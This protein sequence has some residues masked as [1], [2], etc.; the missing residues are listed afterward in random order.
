M[1]MFGSAHCVLGVPGKE[2]RPVGVIPGLTGQSTHLVERAFLVPNHDDFIADWSGCFQSGMNGTRPDHG[3]RGSDGLVLGATREGDSHSASAAGPE[4]AGAEAAGAKTA[5]GS[6]GAK[7][8]RSSSGAEAA[9]TEA[10]RSR[11]WER[12][13]GIPH[14]DRTV[15][16]VLSRNRNSSSVLIERVHG[17]DCIDRSKNISV[18]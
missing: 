12:I 17:E 11:Q 2:P 9:G 16:E 5:G 8:A 13:H 7:A 10:A 3:G 15:D 18:M 1:V 6:S 4:S 14:V